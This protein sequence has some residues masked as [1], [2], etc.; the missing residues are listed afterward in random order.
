MTTNPQQLFISTESR[1]N[2][3]AHRTHEAN[4]WDIL[5]Y[6]ENITDC[7]RSLVLQYFGERFDRA[8]CR[9]S[10]STACDNCRRSEKAVA[11]EVTLLARD[12]VRAV[13]E[14]C[15]RTYG[16]NFTQQQVVDL[17]KG[18]RAKKIMDNGESYSSCDSVRFDAIIV[19]VGGCFVCGDFFAELPWP[20]G[21]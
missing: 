12:V 5:R 13:S 11:E 19:W 10:P 8:A 20:I 17:L 9:G 14:I 4:L 21:G 16:G 6:A 2:A 1:E 18:S 15:Q 3:E 7:R